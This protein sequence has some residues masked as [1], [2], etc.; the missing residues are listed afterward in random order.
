MEVLVSMHSQMST[1]NWTTIVDQCKWPCCQEFHTTE[2]KQSHVLQQHLGK[3]VD[4]QIRPAYQKHKHPALNKPLPGARFTDNS[5]DLAFHENQNWK[6]R[7]VLGYASIDVLE[8]VV[9]LASPPQLDQTYPMLAPAILITVDD[10]DADYK[11]RGVHL[12]QCLIT[13]VQSNLLITSGLGK[14]F[15][16]TLFH[17]L[18]YIRAD[19]ARPDLVQASY[20]S[21]RDLISLLADVESKSRIHMCERLLTEGILLSGTAELWEIRRIGIEQIPFI[22]NELGIMTVQYV[23]SILVLICDI[24]E[25]SHASSEMKIAAGKVLTPVMQSCR[26]R[27]VPDSYTHLQKLLLS[28]NGITEYRFIE[29]RSLSLW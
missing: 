20:Q 1:S 4:E 26:P 16:E 3:I 19:A 13:K 28:N 18:T 8:W 7:N 22:C 2:E 29:V 12:I 25:S 15:L 9:Q 27:S 5:L 17:C 24:L 23:K 11:V 6:E 21:C 14:V 10:F